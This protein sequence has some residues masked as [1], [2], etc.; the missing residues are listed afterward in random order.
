MAVEKIDDLFQLI[1]KDK[2]IIYDVLQ[3]HVFET[4]SKCVAFLVNFDKSQKPKVTFRHISF[5]LAPKSISILSDC[6]RVVKETAKVC[7]QHSVTSI[8]FFIYI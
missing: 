2:S 3:A 8:I 4:E 7:S 1:A 5:Q 6:S